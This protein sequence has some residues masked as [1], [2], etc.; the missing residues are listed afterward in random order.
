MPCK[1]KKINIE[2]VKV[3]AKKCKNLLVEEKEGVNRIYEFLEYLSKSLDGT[4]PNCYINLLYEIT[5]YM[6]ISGIFRSSSRTS[7]AALKSVFASIR[8]YEGDISHFQ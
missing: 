8:A 7:V 4:V 5:K 3:A 2:S 1:P 6:A